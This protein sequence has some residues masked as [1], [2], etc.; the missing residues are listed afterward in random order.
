[1]KKNNFQIAVIGSGPGGAIT[2]LT[3]LESG[4]DVILI[5][6]GQ[7]YNINELNH[8]SYDEMVKKYNNSGL[9]MAIGNPHINYVEGSCFGG[10]SEVNSGLYHRLPEKVLNHWKSEFKIDYSNET[11]DQIYNDI[12]KELN[13]SYYKTNEIPRASLKLLEASIKMGLDCIEVPRWVKFLNNKYEKQSMSETYLKRYKSLGGKYILAAEVQKIRKHNNKI[14][15][16]VVKQN[17]SLNIETN[18][19]FVCSGAIHS[20][21]LLM[22]SGIKKNIGNTLKMHPSFKFIAKFKEDVNQYKMGVPVHQIRYSNKVTI[23]CSISNKAY[24]GVGLSESGNLDEIKNWGKLA[25]YYMMISPESFGKIYKI[26][27]LNSPVVKYLL[28]NRDME[29]I[30]YGIEKMAEVL[31]NS[32]ATELYPSVSSN[33]KIKSIKEIQ[34]I[35]RLNKKKLNLMTIHLF[36]SIRM[37][38]VKKN[39]GV[40]PYGQLWDHKNIFINDSSIL[41]DSTGVNPQGTIMAFSKY[42]VNHFIDQNKLNEI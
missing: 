37:G 32:G 3:L 14:I 29:K 1:M 8:Y 17:K 5:E 36:S 35:K 40:N 7:Y 12:E 15:L 19:L 10:G 39:S 24:L 25:S 21:F 28:N 27:F 22:K 18:Y 30:Y 16:D 4:F 9:T 26:P 11:L 13:V 6:K 38:G 34:K 23:G 31:F 33:L 42:N 20:P 2:A 41:C